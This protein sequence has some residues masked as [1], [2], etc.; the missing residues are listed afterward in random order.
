MGDRNRIG[1]RKKPSSDQQELDIFQ[2]Q[3]D[4][5]VKEA[6]AETPA[7]G[8]AQE[9]GNGSFSVC[10]EGTPTAGMSSMPAAIE[11][12]AEALHDADP[13]APLPS[14][15]APLPDVI[16]A[17]MLNEYVYCP[18]L[19]YYEHVE[20]IFVDNAD[21]KRGK[22]GHRRVDSGKGELAATEVLADST[23]ECGTI[24]ARSVSL[25]SSR[26]GVT[27]KLDL[28]EAS[29]APDLVSGV[30]V[31]PVEYKSGAP[32]EGDEALEIWPADR[33]QLG[34]QILLLRDNGYDCQR[35]I[36]Y[37]RQ[38][39]QRVPLEFSP[40]L[41][42][43]VIEQAV[44]A[45]RISKGPIPPPLAA[46]NKCIRCS[47]N[48]VCLP[49]ETRLLTEL[50]EKNKADNGCMPTDV[51]AA[52]KLAVPRRL[53]PSR[54]DDRALYLNT[55]GIH[56]TQKDARLVVKDGKTVLDEVRLHE[57]SHVALFGNIQITTQAVQ[58]L[59]EHE[60][61]LTYFSMGGWFYGITHGHGLKNVFTRIS[62]F[63]KASEPAASL[64]LARQFVFGKIRNHRTMLMRLH[65]EPPAP[66]IARLKHLANSAL[67]AD[68]LASLLGTE[69]AAAA[70]Y[71][72]EFNGLLKGDDDFLD[73]DGAPPE[74]EFRFLFEGRNRRPP[75]DPVNAMLSL[76]YSLLA[77]DCTLA[78]AAVGLDPYVG[79]FHQ[80][81]FG[82]PALAL[83]L[84]EEF[85]PLIAESTVINCINN[86]MLRPKHFVR[87]GQAVNLSQAGRKIFFQAYEQR[88]NSLITHPI[89]DYKISYRRVIEVQFRLLSRQLTGEIPDYTA[90]MT[91]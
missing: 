86:R 27:A 70:A 38:T 34:L 81:R 42:S 33:M 78:A 17:R 63:A 68:S 36:L 50:T 49:D 53:V 47:L 22:A 4:E 12:L 72:G 23:P 45:R 15:D 3:L 2:Q 9:G 52:R 74:P 31:C 43:W 41:E 90:F 80:P 18:R 85:R 64:Q 59:C 11:D 19:F 56:V 40:D 60:I 76:A 77:K 10:T 5:V 14:A 28:V 48:A 73:I 44:S 88:M 24:H 57:L 69:G 67:N 54:D 61:P 21:T 51:I 84:M 1:R 65:A 7:F 83:D 71:F 66:T 46:S 87:A 55:P 26:L 89:F 39:K 32:R 25:G 35:G 6:F 62:Q 29:A 8:D 75:T 20:G 16:P 82:R 79:F 91:R 58:S 37:Y 30:A 13:T